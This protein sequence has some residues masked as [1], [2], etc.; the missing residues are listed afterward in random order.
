[1][2]PTS[3]TRTGGRWSSSATSSTAG[4]TACVSANGQPPGQPGPRA[5]TLGNHDD[6]FLRWLCGEAVDTQKGGLDKTLAEIEARPDRKTLK[7]AVGGAVRAGG[8]LPG[9]G[10][11]RAD[12]RPCGD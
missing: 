1:M 4:R 6:A 7:K 2:T 5:L 9:A 8:A 10:R 11:G 12:R 3:T